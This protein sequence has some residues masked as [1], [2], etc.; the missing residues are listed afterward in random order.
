M[1]TL[2]DLAAAPTTTDCMA[3]QCGELQCFAPLMQRCMVTA[4]AVEARRS[5][6]RCEWEGQIDLG[7]MGGAIWVGGVVPLTYPALTA[8]L[9]EAHL[10]PQPPC[11]RPF[12]P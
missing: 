5:V 10:P 4:S 12:T 3:R 11:P 1:A 8:L 2:I 6:A 7:S 9:R